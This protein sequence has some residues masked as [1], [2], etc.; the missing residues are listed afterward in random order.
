[1]V[2]NLGVTYDTSHDRLNKIPAIIKG[3]IE[4][5]ESVRFDRS[6]FTDFGD[7]SLNYETVYYVLSG[8][9]ALYRDIQQAINL[10]IK[11]EFD[12]KKIEFAF[13]SQT[14]YLQK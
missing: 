5:M 6:H 9:Y 13:P 4:G 8:D 11:K 3:I 12:K 2:F 14:I 1:M 7:F 10:A